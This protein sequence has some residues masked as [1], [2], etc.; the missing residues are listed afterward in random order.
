M[1]FHFQQEFCVLAYLRSYIA[2]VGDGQQ[3][4]QGQQ[5]LLLPR[6]EGEEPGQR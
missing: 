3:T 2:V 4:E 6:Q 5:Y 1:L